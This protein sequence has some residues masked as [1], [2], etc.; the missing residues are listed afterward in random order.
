MAEAG[1]L[2]R[3]RDFANALDVAPQTIGVWLRQGRLRAVN[4]PNGQHRIPR[5][6]LERIMAS[7]W[8]RSPWTRLP[9]SAQGTAVVVDNASVIHRDD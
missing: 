7:S 8:T 5:S 6:E 2:M 4:L 3:I 1:P 9:D